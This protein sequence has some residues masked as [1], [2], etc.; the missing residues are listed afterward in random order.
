MTL[1]NAH[2][3]AARARAHAKQQADGAVRF[4]NYFRVSTDKQG[5]SGSGL[6]AQHAAIKQF[7][8]LGAS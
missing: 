2:I 5:I 6:E 8:G 1:H 7:L 4:V 3:A